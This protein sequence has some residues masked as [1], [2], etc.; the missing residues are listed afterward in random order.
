MTVLSGV[1]LLCLFAATSSQD[2]LPVP[3]IP[4]VDPLTIENLI[5][6][7]TETEQ[8]QGFMEACSNVDFDALGN[9][10]VS[11]CSSCYSVFHD[12]FVTPV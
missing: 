10:T 12:F 8:T 1:V 2:D 9:S 5:C 11:S 6:F 3:M 4:G 7:S